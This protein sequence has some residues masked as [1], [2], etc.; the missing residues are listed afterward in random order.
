MHGNLVNCKAMIS[1]IK[2]EKDKY[3]K[4]ETKGV[5][6]V[7]AVYSSHHEQCIEAFSRF[8]IISCDWPLVI[9]IQLCQ[10]SNVKQSAT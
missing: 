9:E 5:D 6:G 2:K 1:A 4:Q 7:G 3:I 8:L 10:A